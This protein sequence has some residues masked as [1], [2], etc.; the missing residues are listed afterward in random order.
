MSTFFAGHSVPISLRKLPRMALHS[1]DGS[2]KQLNLD[3]SNISHLIFC[4]RNR[5]VW[6]TPPWINIASETRQY[7]SNPSLIF[8]FPPWRRYFHR[9]WSW[10]CKRW[11]E[12]N[13]TDTQSVS[14]VY[15][16][17]VKWKEQMGL[18][19]E[20]L[21]NLFVACDGSIVFCAQGSFQPQ[22]T[23]PAIRAALAKFS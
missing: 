20:D 15:T 19:N 18:L 22:K 21:T 10:R 4:F 2:T 8:L 7:I 17:I 23:P 13:N 12:Q 5:H 9:I 6:D 3:P 11:A 14:A 16:D 1:L